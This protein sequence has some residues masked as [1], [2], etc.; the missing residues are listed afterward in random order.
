MFYVSSSVFLGGRYSKI[1]NLTP[2]DRLAWKAAGLPT[3]T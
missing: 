1:S 2:G 3:E